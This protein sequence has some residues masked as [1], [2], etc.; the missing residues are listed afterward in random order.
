ME[1]TLTY[2]E[3]VRVR[4]LLTKIKGYILTVDQTKDDVIKTVDE[5]NEILN[6]KGE[7]TSNSS[8]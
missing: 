8:I 3:Y 7:D 6:I 1:K 4:N 2:E 5:I